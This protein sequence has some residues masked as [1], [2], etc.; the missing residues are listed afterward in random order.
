MVTRRSLSEMKEESAF[1]IVVLPEP[2]PPEMMSVMRVLT[3]AASSSAIGGRS[4]PIS[5]SLLRLNGFLEN[6]RIEIAVPQR[7]E[8]KALVDHALAN[9]REAL[10]RKLAETSSQQ[11][12]LRSLAETFGL[13]GYGVPVG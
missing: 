6:L 1:S 4:A 5:T 2:V 10:A 3:A 7:G 9:A 8:K 12:L 13:A 11:A